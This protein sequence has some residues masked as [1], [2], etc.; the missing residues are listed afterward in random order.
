MHFVDQEQ[1]FW[2]L[3]QVVHIAVT[4]FLTLFII[5]V[6]IST[7]WFKIKRLFTFPTKGS[8]EFFKSVRAHGNDIPKQN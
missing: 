5:V 6:N 7:T 3:N 2:W 8:Y 4:G 1:N